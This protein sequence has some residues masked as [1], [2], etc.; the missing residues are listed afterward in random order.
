MDFF[1]RL[2]EM[3]TQSWHQHNYDHASFSD[4]AHRALAEM[5]PAEHVSLWDIVRWGLTTSP[6]PLQHDLEA[7]F[8]QPP[9]TVYVGPGFGIAVLFWVTGMPSIHSHG[10]SGAFHVLEGS[11]I[12]TTWTFDQEERLT[13]RLRV[14]QLR[15]EQG[16]LLSAGDSR[17]VRS[18]NEFI[19]ATYHLDRP[20]VSIVV[21]T[22]TDSD[23][24]P[25]FSYLFPSIAYAKLER[26]PEVTR[27]TQILTM[28]LNSGRHVEFCEILKHVLAT[29]DAEAVLHYLLATYPRIS[30]REE[31]HEL[32]LMAAHPQ[33]RL[34]SALS[35]ALEEAERRDGVVQLRHAVDDPDLQF[36][37]ALLLN[38]PDLPSIRAM[39]CQRHPSAKPLD[40][41]VRWTGKL[42]R[43]GLLRTPY[44][45][46]W[47]FVFRCMLEG[48]SSEEVAHAIWKAY[49]ENKTMM[50]RKFVGDLV[51]AFNSHWLWKPLFSGTSAAY[52][53]TAK[54]GARPA[55]VITDSY[56]EPM[57]R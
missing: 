24:L 53:E 5:T 57:D 34:I 44:S 51:G 56:R 16:E 37:L 11:S 9:L 38:M 36:F 10:F 3:I 22:T 7:S 33:G 4:V 27:R 12:H 28:L 14:G 39:I 13:N 17:P 19:H 31:R 50:D 25:Q 20:T 41:I 30:D 15:L 35:P 47:L 26:P 55:L 23:S 45:D 21:R 48:L 42:A 52:E 29:A 32:L 49:P 54:S 18:G 6:L 2:G 43:S 1:A 8:G 46:E 40:I